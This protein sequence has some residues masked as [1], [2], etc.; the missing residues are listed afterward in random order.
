MTVSAAALQTLHRLHRQIGDLRDR[1]DRGPKQVAAME[2]RLASLKEST[3]AAREKVKQA[4]LASNQKQHQLQGSEQKIIDLKARL[5]VANNN[6]EYQALLEQI[7]A[8]EMANSVLS[9]EILESFDKI[10]TLEQT[11]AEAEEDVKKVSAEAQNVAERVERQR[12]GLESE[13]ARV[14][15]ELVEAETQ[16]PADLRAELRRVTDARGEDALAAVE[17]ESCGGCYQLLTAQM[18]SQL[19]LSKPVFC[20]SCGRLLYMAEDTRR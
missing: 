10:E 12:G 3:A 19:L 18:V 4:K 5:N 20:R 15:G 14:R 13:L 16:L 17:A 7:A 9:D 2:A 11:A 8:A 6:R 1:L